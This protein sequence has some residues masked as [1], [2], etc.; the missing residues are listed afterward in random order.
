MGGLAQDSPKNHTMCLRTSSKCFLGC[1]SL[2]VFPGVIPVPDHPLSGCA[3]PLG[4]KL[5]TVFSMA[6]AQKR[7]RLM[8]TEQV[9]AQLDLSASAKCMAQ[10]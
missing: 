9:R 8:K 10:C 6:V 2:G 7:V 3:S 1:G 5:L 4:K